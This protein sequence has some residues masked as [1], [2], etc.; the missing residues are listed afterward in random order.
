MRSPQRCVV[1]C[2]VLLGG[3]LAVAGCGGSGDD[4][5][6]SSSFASSSAS[7]SASPSPSPMPSPAS[8]TPTGSSAAQAASGQRC[9]TS[10][11]AIKSRALG[12]AAGN[13]YAVIEFTNDSGHSCQVYGFPGMQ[14]LK[15][16]GSTVPT[17]V[18]RDPS[19]KSKLVTLPAGATAWTQVSWSAVPGED[20]QNSSQCEPNP[21]STEVTPP[22]ETTHKII[23]W[24]Y[25]PACEHGRIVV[26]ALAAGTGP[27]HG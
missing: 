6:G 21:A 25:G 8:P 14:L 22:D 10:G 27:A 3:C 9:H 15:S 7:P 26:T 20:E 23:K 17:N 19:S 24:P 5:A 4:S 1:G 12:A 2:A 18:V 13:H 16:N 11:L